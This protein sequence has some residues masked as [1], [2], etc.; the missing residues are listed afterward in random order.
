VSL[1]IIII[2]AL[3]AALLAILLLYVN[4]QQS[5]LQQS[6]FLLQSTQALEIRS[7]YRSGIV[8]NGGS[9]LRVPIAPPEQARLSF[10]F[11]IPESGKDPDAEPYVLSIETDSAGAP[12]VFRKELLPV[13]RKQDRSWQDVTLDLS[14]FHGMELRIHFQAKKPNQKAYLSQI[15]LISP[16]DEVEKYNVLLITIDTLRRDHLSAYGYRRSTT[17]ALDALAKQA[18][19]FKNAY[20]T[21][22]MTVPSVTSIMTSTYFAQHHVANNRS[23]FDGSLPTLAQTLRANGYTTAAFVGNAVLKPDRGL[24][25]GFDVYNAH[26]PGSEI[27][28]RLPE[29]DAEKLTAAALNWLQTHNRERFFLWLH[30]QDPH[31]PYNPPEPFAHMFDPPEPSGITLPVVPLPDDPGGIPEYAVLPGIFDPQVYIARY[32][33][34][35]RYADQSIS[36]IVKFIRENSLFSRT[37]IAVTSDHGESLGENDHYFAHGHNVT[38]DLTNVPLLLYVPGKPEQVYSHS[39]QTIDIAPTLLKLLSLKVPVSFLGRFLF[40]PDTS[41]T[42]LAEQPNV[43]WAILEERGRYIYNRTGD[44]TITGEVANVAADYTRVQDWIEKNLSGGLVLAFSGGT[45]SSVTITSS[46]PLRRAYLFSGEPG[47]FIAIEPQR[48]TLAL[49]AGG[50]DV[51][52][53]FVETDPTATLTIDGRSVMDVEGTTIASPFAAS[54]VPGSTHVPTARD[55]ASPGIIAVRFPGRVSTL[56]ISPEEDE[57]LKS[58]GYVGQ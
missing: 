16:K 13:E 27:N 26:L 45:F 18:A 14:H 7:D 49:R 54:A 19:L 20:S 44:E 33:A 29:R 30:Y 50:S 17:P 4:Q 38:S 56:K 41:R 55:F 21:A 6:S 58:I 23:A 24:Y 57:Q 52:Y 9:E 43:R 28:R 11:G 40:L 22:P 34:E 47:D 31:A 8:L 39:V 5:N 3:A 48:I 51:D 2:S 12:T 25:R 10:S 15:K 35:I 36:K 1:R 37:M 53:V 42:I 32:D 46:A